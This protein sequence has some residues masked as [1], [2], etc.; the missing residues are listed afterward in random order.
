MDPTAVVIAIVVVTSVVIMGVI[1]AA[2]F[3]AEGVY[4]P[5]G[6]EDR[7]ALPMTI[8]AAKA[9]TRRVEFARYTDPLFVEGGLFGDMVGDLPLKLALPLPRKLSILVVRTPL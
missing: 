7:K 3:V 1:V 6:T 4:C 2:R 5:F 9:A 8:S